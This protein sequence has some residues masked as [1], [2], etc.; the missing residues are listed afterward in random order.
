MKA[1]FNFHNTKLMDDFWYV[2]WLLNAFLTFHLVSDYT[3]VLSYTENWLNLEAVSQGCCNQKPGF[4][5]WQRA[6]YFS[7]FYQLFVHYEINFLCLQVRIFFWYCKSALFFGFASSIITETRRK[8][9]QGCCM[10]SFS[11]GIF[12]LSCF[13]RAKKIKPN[14]CNF[15]YSCSCQQLCL[16]RS[17]QNWRETAYTESTHW[18]GKFFFPLCMLD[19]RTIHPF[20]LLWLKPQGDKCAWSTAWKQW[21]C[22]RCFCRTVCCLWETIKLFL[23]KLQ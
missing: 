1:D 15:F 13:T 22:Q 14:S 20:F 2:R 7:F 23:K 10:S 5:E 16:Y 4:I 21:E 19:R 8:L 12:H 6:R 9:L 18:Q 11:R 3:V 17:R